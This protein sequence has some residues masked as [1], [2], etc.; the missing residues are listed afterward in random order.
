MSVGYRCALARFV[1]AGVGNSCGT[2]VEL[3]SPIAVVSTAGLC[4]SL[5]IMPGGSDVVVKDVVV[6]V[7]Q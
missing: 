3:W 6:G 4:L 2:G 7:V 5:R 1:Q